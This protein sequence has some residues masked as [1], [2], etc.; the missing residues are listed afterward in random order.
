MEAPK[1]CHSCF[2]HCVELGAVFSCLR[3]GFVKAL[4]WFGCQQHLKSI[5]PTSLPAWVWQQLWVSRQVHPVAGSSHAPSLALCRLEEQCDVPRG[6]AVPQLCCSPAVPGGF[7]SWG[8]GAVQILGED[9]L[10]T[11]TP[12]SLQVTAAGI[13]TRTVYLLLPRVPSPSWRVDAGMISLGA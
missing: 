7:L 10:G 13:S 5:M 4:C 6:C 11:G 2:S 12:L 1:G 9:L 8:A 3:P